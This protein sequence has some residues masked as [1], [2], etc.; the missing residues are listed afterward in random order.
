MPVREADMGHHRENVTSIWERLD[1]EESVLLSYTLLI[2]FMPHSHKGIVLV[3]A[4]LYWCT[5]YKGSWVTIWMYIICMC[6]CTQRLPSPQIT[7]LM[8][9]KVVVQPW[10]MV[11]HTRYH[12]WLSHHRWQSGV[13]TTLPTLTK[14]PSLNRNQCIPWERWRTSHARCSKR[15]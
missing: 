8:Q 7:Q 12:Q 4:A 5:V 1:R 3:Y 14:Q 15:G 11:W 6:L 13:V 10:W 2:K 9:R